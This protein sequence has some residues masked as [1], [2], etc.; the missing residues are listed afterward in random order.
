MFVDYCCGGLLGGVGSLEGLNLLTSAQLGSSARAGG[1][2]LAVC[3]PQLPVASFFTITRTDMGR[4]YWP[5]ASSQH[6]L[7][8]YS[9]GHR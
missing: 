2:D 1:R 8:G 3:P 5:Y 6:Q 9:I 4:S 7:C